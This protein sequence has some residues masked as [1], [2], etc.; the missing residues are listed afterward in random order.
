MKTQADQFINRL[1]KIINHVFDEMVK[2]V[3]NLSQNKMPAFD[4]LR[5]NCLEN[6][7]KDLKRDITNAYGKIPNILKRN[8]EAAEKMI[9]DIRNLRLD[10]RDNDF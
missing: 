6:Q 7:L 2:E 4:A 8:I 1:G 10:C 3:V 9:D 5:V